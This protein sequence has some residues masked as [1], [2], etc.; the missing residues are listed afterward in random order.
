MFTIRHDDQNLFVVFKTDSIRRLGRHGF[1]DVVQTSCAIMGKD[2]QPV[3]I[4]RAICSTKDQMDE[5]RGM[6]LALGRALQRLTKDKELREKFWGTFHMAATF[7]QF[8][9]RPIGFST[10]WSVS[11]NYPIATGQPEGW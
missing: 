5:I 1:E 6:E 3:A 9:K 8:S 2:V 4:G 10:S 7:E 11:G